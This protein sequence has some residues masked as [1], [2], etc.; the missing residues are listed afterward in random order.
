MIETD[1]TKFLPDLIEVENLFKEQ[2]AL[3]IKHKFI[4][5][6]NKKDNTV[7]IN[8][9]SYA[10]G[11]FLGEKDEIT[12]KR[13]IKRYAKLAVYRTLSHIFNV[14]LAWGSLTGIRPTK[15]AY[16]EMAGS[17]DFRDFFEKDLHFG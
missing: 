8:C 5:S 11:S 7:I 15:L 12:R 1:L 6:G 16:Q 9:K 17:G 3:N 4:E 14:S 10:N 2:G 13:L